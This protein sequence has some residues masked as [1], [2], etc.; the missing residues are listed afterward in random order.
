MVTHVGQIRLTVKIRGRKEFVDFI[1]V[2]SY[3]PYMAIQSRPWIHSM[4]AVPSSLHKKVKFSIGQ[5][6][7]ELRK[8]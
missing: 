3:S 6:I 8:D 2:H 5:G 1:V 7:Y 4:W